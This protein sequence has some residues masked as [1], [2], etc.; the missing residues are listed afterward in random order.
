[1]HYEIIDLGDGIFMNVV[2]QEDFEADSQQSITRAG[3]TLI[4]DGDYTILGYYKDG[5]YAGENKGTVKYGIY[6]PTD[7]FK[8]HDGEYD[9]VCVREVPLSSD[10]M[11]AIV[12]EE[13]QILCAIRRVLFAFV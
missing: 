4:T 9:F 11:S 2:L 12:K 10:R 3:D 1:M 7:E 13:Q 5:R 8:F 6:S